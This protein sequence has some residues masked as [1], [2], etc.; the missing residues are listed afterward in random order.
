MSLGGYIASSGYIAR[1]CKPSFLQTRVA[2]EPGGPVEATQEQGRT[3]QQGGEDI[4]P[5]KPL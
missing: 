4:V 1:P 3:T 5:P 2:R